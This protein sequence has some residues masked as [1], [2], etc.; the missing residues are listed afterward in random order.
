[1]R[2]GRGWEWEVLCLSAVP[3]C[4]SAGQGACVRW[5]CPVVPCKSLWSAGVFGRVDRCQ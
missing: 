3:P 5:E 1:M 4:S 2:G